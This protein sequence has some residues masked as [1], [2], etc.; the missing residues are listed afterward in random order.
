VDGGHERKAVVLVTNN[1]LS[2]LVDTHHQFH[3][4]GGKR[5]KVGDVPIC[6][7]HQAPQFSYFIRGGDVVS[8]GPLNKLGTCFEGQ[9]RIAL[10]TEWDTMVR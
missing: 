8:T 4:L 3:E 6:N 5:I 2:L 1:S 10:G 7:F 9:G